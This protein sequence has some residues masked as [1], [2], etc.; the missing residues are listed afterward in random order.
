MDH[1][2]FR[3]G[4]KYRGNGN[5]EPS[6]KSRQKEPKIKLGKPEVKISSFFFASRL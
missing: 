1:L 2:Q 6:A 5:F 4:D 3:A